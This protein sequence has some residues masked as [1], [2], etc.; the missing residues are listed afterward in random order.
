MV[1]QPQRPVSG[2]MSIQIFQTLQTHIWSAHRLVWFFVSQLLLSTLNSTINCTW[3]DPKIPGIVK[4]N[5]FKVFVQVWN[6]SPLWST[7]PATGCSNPS[8]ASN[9]GNIVQNLQRK[10]CQE[11]PTIHWHPLT[12]LPLKILDIVSSIGSG[13]GIAASS[14]RGSTLKGTEVSN[15]YKYFK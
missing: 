10:C 15:L 5:L 9:A 1:L 12:A 2:H 3:R 14:H 8:T 6:F 7:P 13:A 11:P 4:K